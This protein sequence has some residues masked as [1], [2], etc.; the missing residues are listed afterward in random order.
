MQLTLEFKASGCCRKLTI[1]RKQAGLLFL[2]VMRGSDPQIKA[3][4]I[5]PATG[6]PLQVLSLPSPNTLKKGLQYMDG[7]CCPQP[8]GQSG[9]EVSFEVFLSRLFIAAVSKVQR[10]SPLSKVQVMHS[11]AAR[12]GAAR[13]GEGPPPHSNCYPSIFKLGSQPNSVT[14]LR[15]P[16]AQHRLSLQC[17]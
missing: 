8:L 15:T 13:A 3:N 6:L 4:S 9:L 12:A 7:Q 10:C 17:P 11:P 5:V 16:R 2:D 1:L 14:T